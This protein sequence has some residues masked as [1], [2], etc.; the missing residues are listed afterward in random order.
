MTP[1]PEQFDD[2]ARLVWGKHWKERLGRRFR[3]R[4]REFDDMLA[5]DRDI[6][7]EVIDAV[8][9]G[10]RNRRDQIDDAVLTLGGE[11]AA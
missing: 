6:P 1:T 2:C 10:L 3:I 9:D 5:G 4:P 11:R 7:D 8:K